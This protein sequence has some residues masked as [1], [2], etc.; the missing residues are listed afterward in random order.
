MHSTC[1]IH[2]ALLSFVAL[3][4]FGE[5]YSWHY[6]WNQLWHF[7]IDCGH[8]LAVPPR[9]DYV[10]SDGT[11]KGAM[12]VKKGSAVTLECRASGNPVPTITWTRRVSL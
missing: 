12:E 9:I 10:S 8:L 6:E 2:L 5:K 11:R 1:H 7:G 3:V 4:L